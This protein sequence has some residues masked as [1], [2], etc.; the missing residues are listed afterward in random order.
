MTFG[1]SPSDWLEISTRLILATLI[2]GL[3]GWNRQVRGK[4]AGLRTHMLVSLGA[5]LFILTPLQAGTA[6]T[7]AVSRSIQG[8]A[9]GVGFLGAGEILQQS[10]TETGK[11]K[12]KGLTSAAAIWVTAA[13]GIAAA[14]GFWQS[15]LV[16]TGLALL[17]LNAETIERF[18]P[19]RSNSGE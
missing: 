6:T 19:P 14:C 17:I 7:E 10:R 15:A 9:T 8:V 3:I 11:A 13:L 2:G 16:A 1:V 5:A 4:A 12:V 18:I